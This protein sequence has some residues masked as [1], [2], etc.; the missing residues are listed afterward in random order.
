[1]DEPIRV[2]TSTANGEVRYEQ[3]WCGDCDE[4]TLKALSVTKY[5]GIGGE[6]GWST[7]SFATEEKGS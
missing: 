3:V 1:M 6:A 2:H 4:K 5:D 7:V